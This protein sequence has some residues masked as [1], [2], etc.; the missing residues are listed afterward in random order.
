MAASMSPSYSLAGMKPK[1]QSVSKTM[2]QT[3]RVA[4]RFQARRWVARRWWCEGLETFVAPVLGR[5]PS[6]LDRRPKCPIGVC[7]PRRR[8]RRGHTRIVVD[9]NGWTAIARCRAGNAPMRTEVTIAD[10]RC[11]EKALASGGTAC[12]EESEHDKNGRQRLPVSDRV[13][14]NER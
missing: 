2:T 9:P 13:R 7:G 4:A 10:G 8:R 11:K 5:G 6:P 1:P 12:G 3:I 14:S